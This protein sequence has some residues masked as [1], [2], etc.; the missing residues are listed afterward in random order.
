MAYQVFLRD[1]DNKLF[2]FITFNDISINK[3]TPVSPMPLP[4][5]DSEDNVLMKIEGNT[6]TFTLNWLLIDGTSPFGSGNIEWNNSS[7]KWE[8][9]TILTTDSGSSSWSSFEQVQKLESDYAS[10]S[11]NDYYTVQV[12]S[13]EGNNSNTDDNKFIYEKKGLVQGY[14][15]RTDSTSPVN[16]TSTLDFIEGSVVTT[17][18][19]NTHEAPKI[20]GT[21]TFIGTSPRTGIQVSFEEFP[22]Y[23]A[24]D[25]PVTT[26]AVLRYRKKAG[27]GFWKE[28]EISF[29]ATTGNPPA[30]TNKQ[31][32]TTDVNQSGD[33]E[34][35]LALITTGGRG[36]WYKTPKFVT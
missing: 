23:A 8:M 31:F 18:S 13:T 7:G 11:L 20:T 10:N 34:I 30:Y 36:E 17:L 6:T 27:V 28:S 9:Q 25:R 21:P 15:F 5:E 33:T 3:Q 19:G 35:R 4:E 2:E 22:N 24:N 26:G 32:T 29:T 1:K 12:F 16:W 14:T